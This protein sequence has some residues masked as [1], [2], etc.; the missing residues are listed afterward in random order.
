[1]ILADADH[2]WE[3]GGN[4]QWVW[5]SFL[6]GLNPIFIDPYSAEDFQK[7]S[8]KPEWELIRR[9]MGYTLA[10]AHRVN[11]TEMIP[12]PDIVT[13]G[14]CLAQEGREY[15]VYA[16][17]GGVTVDLSSEN[18]RF[19][20]EWLDPLSGKRSVGDPVTGGGPRFLSSPFFGDGVLY[21]WSDNAK[22]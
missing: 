22:R 17:K 3:V 7:H 6:R 1:V 20:V 13:S 19:S 21:L 5:K 15:L 16:G 10:F 4:W 8:S 12:R 11:L 9:N 2:L 14:Y 18:R